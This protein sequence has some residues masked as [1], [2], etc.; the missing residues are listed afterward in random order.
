MGQKTIK[1][2]IL[3]MNSKVG[4]VQANYRKVQEIT[5]RELPDD[6]D[7]LV[8]PE[9]WTVGWSCEDFP[10]TSEYLENS[11]AVEFLSGLATKHNVNILGGSL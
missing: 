3:Q 11:S 8:L 1:L 7:F 5:E 2:C 4:D 10:V 9:V 6:A